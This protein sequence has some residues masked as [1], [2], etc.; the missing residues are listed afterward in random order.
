MY[1]L[2]E[3]RTQLNIL[4]EKLINIL[5]ERY[6]ICRAIADFKKKHDIPM[7]QP[8]RVE[9]V[10]N[11]CATMAKNKNLNPDFVRNLYTLIIDEACRLED[12]I[13]DNK[14]ENIK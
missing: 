14:V 6:Q 13:I 1:R 11:R 10:K 3:F 2:D 4:D 8:A 5:S 7:M 9:E 12:D